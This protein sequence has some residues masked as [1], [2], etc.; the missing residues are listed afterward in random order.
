MAAEGFM[1]FK[2]LHWFHAL[3]LIPILI[4]L[5]I[6]HFQ[7]STESLKQFTQIPASQKKPLNLLLRL[8]LRFSALIGI[9]FALSQPAWNPTATKVTRKGRDIVFIIDVSR[10]MLAEDLA[11]NRLARA[12]ISVHDVLNRFQDHRV[13]L[14]AF[15]GSSVVKCPLTFDHNFMKLALEDLSP[16]S[17][18]RGGSLIGDALRKALNEVFVDDD[19]QRGRD[20]ILISDGEDQESFPLEAAKQAEER[21]IRIIALGLGDDQIGHP[22]PVNAA[23]GSRIYLEYQGQRVLS[24]LVPTTLK[25]IASATTGG[26]YL[27]VSTGHIDLDEVYAQ[28]IADQEV[29]DLES[30]EVI[31]YQEKFQLFLLL[32]FIC[33]FLEGLIHER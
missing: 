26:R 2:A 7:K 17:I 12:R 18:T 28:L 13:A 16:E 11:P 9:I 20:I 32:G 25:G 19:G 8:I 29:R 21:G 5:S 22:I 24:Q 27:H 3:W 10:S 33:L 15:A 4:L 14:I 1:I 30:K 6:R 31:E 23:N